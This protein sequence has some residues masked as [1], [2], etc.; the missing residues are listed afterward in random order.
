[1]NIKSNKYNIK[2]IPGDISQWKL[3]TFEESFIWLAGNNLEEKSKYIIKHITVN[4]VINKSIL[5]K[6]LQNMEDHFGIVYIS[7]KLIFAAVDCARSYPIFWKKAKDEFLFSP[8]A[9]NI[10]N[11]TQDTL[12]KDQ[13]IA[14]RMSGYTMDDKTL[15]KNIINLNPGNFILIESKAN[16]FIEEYF[17]YKPWTPINKPYNEF[18]KQLKFEINKLLKNIIINANGRTI[19]IP[20]SAGLDSRLIASGLKNLNYQKVKCFS[21]GLKNNFESKASRIIANKLGY[22]WKFVEYNY[23]N[24]RKFF[25]SK[26]FRSYLSSTKS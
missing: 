10:F 21:Y 24:A 17:S 16:Y 5:K 9:K 23:S 20:L 14:Y 3:F 8:Q 22:E 7:K 12:D 19:I 4:K 2:F 18:K 25:K 15:W 1:M 26:K 6:I 13:I 11:H